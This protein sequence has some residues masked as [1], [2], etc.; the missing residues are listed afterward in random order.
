[1]GYFRLNSVHLTEGRILVNW[2]IWE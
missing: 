2:Q 1:V